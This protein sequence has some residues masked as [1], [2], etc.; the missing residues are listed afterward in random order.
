[1]SDDF[2]LGE[3]TLEILKTL[4]DLKLKRRIDARDAKTGKISSREVRIDAPPPKTL[5]SGSEIADWIYI[6]GRTE[7][8][9]EKEFRCLPFS[10]ENAR[11]VEDYLD[12][13][14]PA[15][16]ERPEPPLE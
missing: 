15:W 4:A 12:G 6:V 14:L 8:G 13:A 10:S 16:K 5:K 11:K 3:R 9:F 7:S 2:V 1:M